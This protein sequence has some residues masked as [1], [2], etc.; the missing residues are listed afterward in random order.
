MKN[1]HLQ[2]GE[3]QQTSRVDNVEAA[4]YQRN[5]QQRQQQQLQ[6]ATWMKVTKRLAL[7]R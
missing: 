6:N 3:Q 4:K 2:H 5:Q 1:F 7:G